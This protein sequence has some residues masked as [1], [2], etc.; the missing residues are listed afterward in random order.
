M[1]DRPCND[2]KMRSYTYFKFTFSNRS[3]EVDKNFLFQFSMIW[4]VWLPGV[5]W[6]KFCFVKEAK[7]DWLGNN[8]KITPHR[9]FN[10]R[11]FERSPD[12]LR[13]FFVLNTWLSEICLTSL[14]ALFW[15]FPLLFS[16]SKNIRISTLIA[17]IITYYLLII[18]CIYKNNYKKSQ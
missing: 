18:N 9:N 5:D 7:W 3:W 12:V 11:F 14:I 2:G 4:K 13:G 8:G 10:L 17:I 6:F 1:S 15:N 16:H